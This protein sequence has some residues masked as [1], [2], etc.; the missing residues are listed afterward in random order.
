MID[1]EKLSPKQL[2][3]LKVSL[4]QADAA[5]SLVEYI[6]MCWHVLEPGRT[7]VRGWH[8]D[9]MCEHLQAV[10]DGQI[11]RL[12]M[13]VPPGFMKSM[14]TDVFFP[15]WEWGPKDCPSYRYVAASYSED[16]TVRD[17]RK[18]RQLL[19]S[20]FY[21]QRW[22]HIVQPSNT[23]SA[24]KRFD[25]RQTGFKVATSIGG[26]GTGERGDRV[27]VDDP[28]NVREGESEAK[29][30]DAIRWFTETLPTRVNDPINS[31]IIVIMQRVHEDDVSGYILKNDLGYEHLMIPM[32]FEPS[33]KCYTSI[34]FE[35]PRTEENELAWPERMPRQV[36]ERDKKVMGSYATA[37]QFQQRP[38]PRGG[39]MFQ[40]SWFE[41]VDYTEVPKGGKSCRA[42]DLA[43]STR[44]KS[45]YTV[46]L[47]LRYVDGVYYIMD[48]VRDRLSPADVEKLI[49]R[50]AVSDGESRM[51]SIPQ[52]PGQAG[53]AQK[54]YLSNLLA[55]YN[56]RFSLETG[57]KEVRALS[58]AAQAEAGNVKI[59]KAPWNGAF[60]DELCSFPMASYKDQVDALS[61]A[62][63]ELIDKKGRARIATV[64]EAVNI[65][66]I[67]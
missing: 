23:Q 20:D 41:F 32:E 46:G 14:L 18:S 45:A 58:V 24:K 2:A 35:D 17:N 43:G 56:A 52:D 22:G 13:N 19:S 47:E 44:K 51:I 33:R 49:L 30:E 26:L 64:C 48:V 54:R 4:D 37:G 10:H 21:Q 29:R 15:T 12:L 50:T 65:D 31:A 8:I 28:H 9:A 57:S 6:S 25:T 66:P 67:H 27:I 38:V 53:K 7:F 34:G 16:L 11:N 61:R 1:L 59:V 55:G 63:S 39:G 40:H 60:M 3:Q 5:E 42:W 36:I 62:F